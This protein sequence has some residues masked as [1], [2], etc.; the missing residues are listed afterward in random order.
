VI[1]VYSRR[2]KVAI[3]PT[4]PVGRRPGWGGRRDNRCRCCRAYGLTIRSPFSLPCRPAQ[5]SGEPDVELIRTSAD[6]FAGRVSAPL[7]RARGWFVC[8]SL[9]DGSTYLRWRGLFEFLVSPDGR[10]IAFRHLSRATHESFGVYLLGQVLSFS[11]LARGAETLHGTVVSIEGQGIAL[12]G[13]CGDGKSTLGAALL[14]RGFPI[15]TDDLIALERRG[16]NWL[17]HP[18]APRLKLFP[19]VARA[20]LGASVGAARMN[21]L[22]PKLVLP[23][24]DGA[25]STPNAVPLR[26]MYVLTAPD[27]PGSRAT[28]PRLSRVD[29][30]AAFLQIVRS[31]FNLQ[32]LTPQRFETQFAF[33]ASMAATVPVKRLHY[34]RRLRCLPAVCD[35]VL[36]DVRRL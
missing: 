23:L 22:T 28:K 16:Q 30:S 9:A 29:G 33:A 10:R 3:E 36:R 8:R 12:L 19:P 1:S 27:D 17:V 31:V 6:A 11:L 2:E 15:V 14:A 24:A 4:A 13:D 34:P 7:R 5:A 32:V 20:L 35:A 26:A 25:G 21:H 18:G